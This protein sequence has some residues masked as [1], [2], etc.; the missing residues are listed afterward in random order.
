MTFIV[1]H[2]ASPRPAAKL[3]GAAAVTGVAALLLAGSLSPADAAAKSGMKAQDR[4]TSATAAAPVVRNPDTVV[5]DHRP[6]APRD[7]RKGEA[8]GGVTSWQTSRGKRHIPC[9]GNLCF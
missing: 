6:G 5:R 4:K 1:T 9:Y 3:V 8:S 7:H 2:L